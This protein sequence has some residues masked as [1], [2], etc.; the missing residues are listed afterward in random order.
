MRIGTRQVGNGAPCLII[1]E[2][3]QAHD[4]SLGMAHAYVD[5]VAAAGADVVKFQT[6]IAD[7]E[8]TPDEPFRIRFSP[9]D[10]TRYD[11]WKRMEFTPEQWHDLAGHC[12]DRGLIFLSSPFSIEAVDLLSGLGMPA[13]KI[14]SGEVSNE[15]LLARIAQEG[16][17]VLFSSG[18]SGWAELDRSIGFVRERGVEV[19]VFQCTTQYPC[20]PERIGLDVIPLLRQRYQCPVGLSDHSGTI[21]AGLAA[22]A[23]GLDLLEV[24][25][26]M[27]R[28]MFGP[29]VA[30]SLTTAELRQLVEGVRFIERSLGA[31]VD[32][33]ALQ[34]EMQPLRHVFL[35]SVVAAADLEA[36]TVL[37]GKHMTTKKPGTGIPARELPH[38][39]GRVLARRVKRDQ[40]LHY[41]DLVEE[42]PGDPRA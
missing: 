20:P 41:D 25:V 1:A 30:A 16:K 19:A 22:V 27:S 29:D 2:I 13:Y 3:A 9:Q 23:R 7:A 36:G 5:A 26:T 24:H 8:S 40:L 4:G 31:P 39:I 33:D 34:G 42:Q 14:A 28:E 6:H 32:K 15:V 18:M 17:P 10:A 21:F 38:L 37:T 35:Q 12:A 11:Y